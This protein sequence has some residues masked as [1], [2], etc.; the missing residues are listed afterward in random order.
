MK[1]SENVTIMVRAAL[2]C[3][4]CDIPAAKKV[5]GFLGHRAT[6]GCSKCL[7]RFPVTRFGEKPD[8]S[9]F[10]RGEWVKRTNDYHRSQVLKC[11][12]CTTKSERTEL[13]RWCSLQLL[14]LPYFN[15][16]RMCIINPMHNLLLGTAKMMTELWKSSGI[17]D[18]KDFDIIQSRV[19][20][21]VCPSEIGRIPSK[22]GS[23]FSGFTAEQWKIGQFIFHAMQSKESFHGTIIIAGCC[24]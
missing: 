13:E 4:G 6:M 12:K 10:N 18:L 19:D 5:C 1:T 20:S 14:E 15:A 7:L 8:Y 16:P 21:F 22:I 3:V 24:L 9:N 2:L 11:S 17:L 23:S